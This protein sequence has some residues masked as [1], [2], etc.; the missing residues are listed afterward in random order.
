MHSKNHLENRRKAKLTF[1]VNV[2]PSLFCLGKYVGVGVTNYTATWSN[3]IP[4]GAMSAL[5]P[6]AE[7]A[8][9]SLFSAM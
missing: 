4:I 7:V 6:K 8:F 5:P 9:G 3:V 2:R 1:L